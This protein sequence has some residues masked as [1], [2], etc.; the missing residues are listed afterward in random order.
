M[1]KDHRQI[2]SK[3]WLRGISFLVATTPPA[4]LL[5]LQDFIVPYLEKLP[6]TIVLRIVLALLLTTTSLLAYIILKRPWLKWDTATGS[7]F[8]VFSGLKY[9]NKCRSNK[10]I[11]PLKTVYGG[12]KC[13]VCG[14]NY[15]SSASQDNPQSSGVSYH[16]Q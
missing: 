16:M 11:T 14:K 15:S 2:I 4:V 5:L 3:W 9:C 6:S 10:I 12:W 13:T 1:N 7:W 8:H